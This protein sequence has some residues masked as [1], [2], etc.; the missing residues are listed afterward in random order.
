MLFLKKIYKKLIFSSYRKSIQKTYLLGSNKH[1]K[2]KN[3]EKVLNHKS[4]QEKEG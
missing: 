4:V 1:A 2:I 3:I